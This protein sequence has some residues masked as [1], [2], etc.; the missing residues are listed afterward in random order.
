M[1]ALFLK[2][3]DDAMKEN[4]LFYIRFMDDWVVIVPTRWKLRRAVA[5]VNR[6]LN[7]LLLEK[8]P[9]KTFIGRADRGFDFLG[10]QFTPERLTVAKKT[11]ER[12][13]ERAA[14]FWEYVKRWFS[15][16]TGGVSTKLSFCNCT[17]TAALTWPLSYCFVPLIYGLRC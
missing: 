8:H 5:L 10:Y 15:W 4:D 1:A 3:L 2:P 6:V 17:H 7:A 13:V 16:V 9:D 12:F 11:V 14:R